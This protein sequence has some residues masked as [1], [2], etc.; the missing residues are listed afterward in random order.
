M[1]VNANKCYLLITD[2]YEPSENINKFE[3]ESCKMKNS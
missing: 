3:T 2:N 1:K